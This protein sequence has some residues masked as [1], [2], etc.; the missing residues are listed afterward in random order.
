MLAPEGYGLRLRPV[1]GEDAEDILALRC[2]PVLGRFL[3]RTVPDVERQRSWIRAQQTRADDYYFAITRAADG[4]FL[5]TIS[6]YEVDRAAGEC[7]WG[8]WVLHPGSPAAI[9]SVVLLF[10]LIVGELALDR[11]YS[12]TMATNHQVVSFHDS[13]GTPR[14]LAAGGGSDPDTDFVVHRTDARTWAT[15]RRRAVRLAE[16]AGRLL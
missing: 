8:R 7:E 9:G 15:L 12:R 5:G 10:D 14:V 13:M 2:D 6:A 3:G 4:A 16:A 1:T 11:F